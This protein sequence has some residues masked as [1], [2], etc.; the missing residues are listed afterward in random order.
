MATERAQRFKGRT[1]EVLV[2]GPN[3]KNKNQVGGEGTEPQAS[4][5]P[6]MPATATHSLRRR[7]TYTVGGRARGS[8]HRPHA[9]WRQ[10]P[11]STPS[12]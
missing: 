6:N 2:E 11:C 1:L 10:G 3:P 7:T 9:S 8:M 5:R 12:L 4:T